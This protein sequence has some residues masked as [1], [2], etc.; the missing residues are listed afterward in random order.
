MTHHFLIKQPL[1]TP[2]LVLRDPAQLS[3]WLKV[4]RFKPG[5]SLVLLDG[6]G[7][8]A[9]ARLET[10]S[11]KEARLSL[12]NHQVEAWKGPKLRLVLA[13]NKQLPRLEWLLQKATELGVYEFCFFTA[14]RSQVSELR[15]VSRLEAIVQEAVEQSER[16]FMPKLGPVWSWEDLL[17]ELQGKSVAFASAREDAA[18]LLEQV[19]GDELNLLI[20][21]EGGFTDEEKIAMRE[22]GFKPF[23]LGP[24]V[25]RFETA[26]LA[27]ASL[28]LCSGYGMD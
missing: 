8:S 21:P 5:Q 25:L 20:G 9:E 11:R 13:L 28:V 19:H 4:L 17:T 1:D 6:Q 12:M 18:P 26:A 27:A 7:G 16:R 3:Q 23:T 15:K 2:E 22:A 14:Q 24:Q 10:L